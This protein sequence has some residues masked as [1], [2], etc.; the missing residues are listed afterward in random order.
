M[1]KLSRALRPLLSALLLAGGCGLSGLSGLSA[2]VGSAGQDSEVRFGP[3]AE[4]FPLTLRTGQRGEA[5]GPLFYWQETPEAWGWGFSP[6]VSYQHEPGVERTQAEF[7]YPL[8][9]F[10]QYGSQYRFHI[11]QFVSWSGGQSTVGPEKRRFT[12]FPFWFSQ[13]SDDPAQAYK[14][15]VPFYGHLKGRL[16]RDEVR[17]AALPLWIQTRK[18]DVVTD[19]YFAPFVH[20]R[21]GAAQGWQVW[22]LYG[23]EHRAP[24]VRTNALSDL[25]EVV[26]GHEKHFVVWPFWITDRQGI[27]SENPVTNTL[28]LPLFSTQRSKTRDNTTLMWPFFTHTVDRERDFEEWGA[29][30]PFVGWADG[31]GKQARRV[32][33]LWG[34][35]SN[36]EQQSEFVLWPFYTHK[37]MLTEDL[38]REQ[39]RSVFY[40]WVD[41]AERDRRN[42]A[43][44]RRRS[45]WP[46]FHHARDRQGRERLQVLALAEGAF[47]SNEGIARSWSPVWS[48]YRHERDAKTGRQSRSLLWNLW[49][50][51][52]GPEGVRNGLF[53]GLFHWGNSVPEVS[54]PKPNTLNSKDSKPNGPK[55]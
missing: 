30:W 37:R 7:L 4:E 24:L 39:T 32:W 2:S 8:V 55:P 46:L 36:A 13:Q 52:S 40:L 50:Q 35:A 19:N 51:E 17:F 54:A 1:T 22:P 21:T 38:D 14:A 20:V 28:S 53:F 31:P 27:G 11:V 48:L 43:E 16:F 3:L 9:S 34:R 42:G 18:R 15:L 49:R 45:L 23:Q 10:D 47:P 25:P 41:V 6:W 29:P 5:L 26:P 12:L 33:P 44:Y